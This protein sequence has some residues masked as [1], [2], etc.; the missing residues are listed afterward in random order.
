MDTEIYSDI[1]LNKYLDFKI[2]DITGDIIRQSI[3]L[4]LKTRYYDRLW[5]PYIGSYI[6]DVI[7]MQ[8]DEYSHLILK[9]QVEQA[10]QKNEPR[11][12][13]LNV[14]VYNKNAQDANMGVVT[15]NITYQILLTEQIESLEIDFKK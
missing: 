8:D 13:V 11:I 9:E 10:L 3:V 2:N 6:Q 14:E 5:A 4:I 7:F 12:K 15:C 1:S